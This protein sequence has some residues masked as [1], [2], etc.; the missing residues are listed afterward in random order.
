MAYFYF[1]F[2]DTSKQSSKG[3]LSSLVMQFSAQLP[4]SINILTQFHSQHLEGIRQPGTDALAEILKEIIKDFQH[5]YIILDALDECTE[6][7]VLLDL[8]KQIVAWKLNN[9]HILATSQTEHNIEE[10][11]GSRASI[12]LNINTALVEADIR[13]H[14][15]KR[16]QTVKALRNCSVPE[17]EEFETCLVEGA[18][19]M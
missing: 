4:G 9:L 12:K 2:I 10:C 1:D 5:A 16:L 6:Q 15:R 13:L 17:Q 3:L 7:V 11:L 8:I 19:G 18:H 14:I